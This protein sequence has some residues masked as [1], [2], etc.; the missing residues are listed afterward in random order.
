MY[1]CT[2]Q[3]RAHVSVDAQHRALDVLRVVAA[4]DHPAAPVHHAGLPEA[5]LAVG[6][7]LHVSVTERTRQRFDPVQ[8]V[9]DVVARVVLP[10]QHAF[11]H[12][13]ARLFRFSVLR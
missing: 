2:K 4:L 3:T 13:D 12:L 8:A 10:A 9:L 11:Q 5:A 1:D 7:A 6:P